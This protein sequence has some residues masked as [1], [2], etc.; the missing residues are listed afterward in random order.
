MKKQSMLIIVLVISMITARAQSSYTTIQYKNT[1]QPAL[2]LELP[3]TAQ[4]VEGTILKKL[5][6]IGYN[7]ETQG[8]L[9]WKKNK[10]DGF[11]V[12]NSVVL[13]SLSAQKLDMY[14]K[15]VKKNNEEKNNTTLYLLVS[16]GNE[17]FASPD[18]DAVLWDNSRMFLNSF[19]EKTTAY[20]LE[21]TITAQESTL[22][23]SQKKLS[24][25]KK[26]EADLADKIKKYQNDLANNQNNQKDQQLDIEN[27]QKLLESMILKRR[28]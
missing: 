14:F 15:V 28:D 8:A 20:N 25:L 12:F 6:Q 3:N 10:I 19:I 4:D 18:N 11:Y 16:S 7:P 24:T 13:P 1:M 23:T 5:K 27:Q 17:N 2:V 26:D 22:K 9:F 21:Q